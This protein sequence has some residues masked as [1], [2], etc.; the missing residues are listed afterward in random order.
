MADG[1]A[2][3]PNVTVRIPAQIRRLHGAQAR[4][5]V[6]ASTVAE[7]VRTLEVRYP[8]MGQRL[9]EPNGEARRWVN[10]FHDLRDIRE[11]GGMAT[12]LREGSEVIIVP[13]VAGG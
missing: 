7:V 2:G 3:A 11:T 1:E 12:P 10:F 13:S 6:Q 9:I 5:V 8:G 4:E